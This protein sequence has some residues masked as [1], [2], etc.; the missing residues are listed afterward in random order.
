MLRALWEDLVG[1]AR[2]AA[3]FPS[4]LRLTTDFLLYRPM[5][6][7]CPPGLNRERR[8]RLRAGIE[9]LYRLNRGDIWALHE[10]WIREIYRL[11]DDRSR[12]IIVDLGA[13]IGLAALY[14]ATRYQSSLLIAVEPVPANADLARRNL[15]RN[16]ICA[17]VLLAA[18]GPKDG[19][20][21]L[22]Q[23]ASSTNST[24]AFTA[25]PVTEA[26]HTVAVLGMSSVLRALPP[27]TPIDLIKM[28]IEG[29][30]EALLR[31]DTSWLQRVRALIVEFHPHLT[32]PS[33]LIP[34]IEASGLERVSHHT[35]APEIV[36]FVRRDE[37]A[38]LPPTRG[39]I[40]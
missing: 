13:N 25:A 18:A 5:R 12:A 3:D 35:A 32:D 29:S 38:A 26:T 40:R 15:E 17:Q 39:E 22:Q 30:E 2:I 27:D 9:I 24:I 28:D 23:T 14:L 36:L 8:V 37:P 31:G 16:N 34:V 20:A 33:P 4:Y 7:F 1:A 21:H 6:F 10:I 19:T 11:P